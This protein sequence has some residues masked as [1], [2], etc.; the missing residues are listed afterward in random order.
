MHACMHANNVS[1]YVQGEYSNLAL[2]IPKHNIFLSNTDKSFHFLTI[3]SISSIV[4]KGLNVKS[5]LGRI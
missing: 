4:A 5:D 2:K 3:L 1:E